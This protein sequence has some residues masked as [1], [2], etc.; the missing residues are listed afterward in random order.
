[1][2]MACSWC[3]KMLPQ[4]SQANQSI[5]GQ[6]SHSICL[7]CIKQMEIF[8]EID[9]TQNNYP[10][11]Y[12]QAVIDK[13]NKITSYETFNPKRMLDIFPNV[14][15]KDYFKEINPSLAVKSLKYKLSGLRRR[16]SDGQLEMHYL[17]SDEDK[18][19]FSSIELTHFKSSGDTVINFKL[20][21]QENQ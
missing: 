10:V 13:E 18:I 3:G 7:P 19:H 14:L 12:G 21:Q 16:K 15:G 2:R 1:M 17:I 5:E 4:N 8:D 11:K 9:L 6:L 20:V